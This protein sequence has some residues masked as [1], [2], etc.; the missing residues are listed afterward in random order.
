MS[1]KRGAKC[2]EAGCNYYIT[3]A[4]AKDAIEGLREHMMEAHGKEIPEELEGAISSEI[5]DKHRSRS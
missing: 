1:R 4:S 3:T 2:P 5:K